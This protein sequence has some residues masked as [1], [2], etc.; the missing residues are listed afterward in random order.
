MVSKVKGHVEGFTIHLFQLSSFYS[1]YEICF[2]ANVWSFHFVLITKQRKCL[3]NT[4][5]SKHDLLSLSGIPYISYTLIGFRKNVSINHSKWCIISTYFHRHYSLKQRFANWNF[6]SVNIR[7]ES[8]NQSARK[9]INE[10]AFNLI[11]T[12]SL[13]DTHM[14][15]L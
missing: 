12:T 15:V 13:N 8:F 4:T 3:S 11:W 2:L 6:F 14:K 9:I 1:F 10:K 7:G 5:S